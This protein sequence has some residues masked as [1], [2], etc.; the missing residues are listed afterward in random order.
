MKRRKIL[1]SAGAL[2][3]AALTGCG[4]G[5]EDGPLGG[6]PSSQ[7]AAYTV[8]AALVPA[9]GQYQVEVVFNTTRAISVT[10]TINN[11]V[12]TIA[13]KTTTTGTSHR[14]GFA[15]CRFNTDTAS[16]TYN[17]GKLTV[18]DGL[19]AT[20]V[21][22]NTA[23]T[24][25][26]AQYTA[27]TTEVEKEYEWNFYSKTNLAHLCSVRF[28][29]IPTNELDT[30]ASGVYAKVI[31]N[32]STH[33]NDGGLTKVLPIHHATTLQIVDHQAAV[34]KDATNKKDTICLPNNRRPGHDELVPSY[35]AASAA[36]R[37]VLKRR[38]M[39]HVDRHAKAVRASHVLDSTD[40]HNISSMLGNEIVRVFG[41]ASFIDHLNSTRDNIVTS[42]TNNLDQMGREFYD[43]C[44]L[45]LP[46]LSSPEMITST[47]NLM[48]GAENGEV[49]SNAA[50]GVG[51]STSLQCSLS[52]TAANYPWPGINLGGGVRVSLG[53]ARES[54]KWVAGVGSAPDTY[55]ISQVGDK[56]VKL[57]FTFIVKGFNSSEFK[58]GTFNSGLAMDIE[59]TANFTVKDGA[60]RL[61][62]IQFDPVIDLD[63]RTWLGAMVSRG[64][65]RMLASTVNGLQAIAALPIAMNAALPPYM[66]GLNTK[67]GTF[68]GQMFSSGAQ[69]VNAGIKDYMIPML[70]TMR[71]KL[72]GTGA[73]TRTWATFELS[74]LRFCIPNSDVNDPAITFRGGF[75]YGG[76]GWQPGAKYI[77]GFGINP[78]Y[79]TP[80]YPPGTVVPPGTP[81]ISAF[82]RVVT[83]MDIFVMYGTSTYTRAS[84]YPWDM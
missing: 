27:I 54:Y 49:S 78:N 42:I 70:Q 40:D 1:T 65:A 73:G 24:T 39:R 57:G 64:L 18:Q 13:S 76:I 82:M 30:Y 37:A 10:L 81:S 29:T 25:N 9:N 31:A 17:W 32:T 6:D 77:V 56:G 23:Q 34:I 16:S 66:S 50:G 19:N 41:G 5:G 45:R 3:G 20:I 26:Y 28:F 43:F 72:D 14:I 21:G 67:M 52:I 62:V 69:L 84:T 11:T 46:T 7:I 44:T 8:P 33:T 47:R 58:L 35:M 51:A 36:E 79:T 38:M 12:Y 48:N 80:Y 2:A 75:R 68:A 74:A 15:T 61:D 60:W 53:L 63:T 22:N 55:D 83:V 4:G 59:V 71:D